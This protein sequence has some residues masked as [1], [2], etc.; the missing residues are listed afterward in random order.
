MISRSRM[1]RPEFAPGW[2]VH[3]NHNPALWGMIAASSVIRNCWIVQFS[4]GARQHVD[5]VLMQ[6]FEPTEVQKVHLST[7]VK[8]WE[9]DHPATASP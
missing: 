1:P 9:R 6:R 7:V 5:D 2:Y 3:R 8:A 4:T